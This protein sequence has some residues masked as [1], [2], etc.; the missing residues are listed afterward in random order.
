[1]QHMW[2]GAYRDP[3]RASDLLAVGMELGSS[4][5]AVS[6]LPEQ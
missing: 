6:T 2:A 1:M 3:K 5:R 4:V